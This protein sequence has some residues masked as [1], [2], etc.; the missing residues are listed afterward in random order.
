[1]YSDQNLT[2]VV[3]LGVFRAELNWMNFVDFHER[4]EKLLNESFSCFAT[5]RGLWKKSML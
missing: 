3:L 4:E 5:W 2:R 1:M